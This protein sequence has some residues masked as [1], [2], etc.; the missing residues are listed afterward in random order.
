MRRKEVWFIVAKKKDP[1]DIKIRI[2]CKDWKDAQKMIPDLQA[3]HPLDLVYA[4][5]CK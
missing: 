5:E 1:T 4:V 2:I 3:E